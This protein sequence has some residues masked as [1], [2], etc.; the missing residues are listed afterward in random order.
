MKCLGSQIK[1][2]S[3]AFCP[4]ALPLSAT[5]FHPTGLVALFPLRPGGLGGN[6]AIGYAD[7]MAKPA[8]G[9]SK[10]NRCRSALGAHA[11]GRCPSA[12]R[13]FTPLALSGFI[14][15]ARTG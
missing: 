15:Y 2:S 5:R 11:Q 12:L 3:R 9:A 7:F 13:A 8:L 14:R 10:G 1:E 4:G 6:F